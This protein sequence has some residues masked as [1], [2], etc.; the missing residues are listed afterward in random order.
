MTVEDIT[1]IKDVKYHEFIEPIAILTTITRVEAMERIYDLSFTLPQRMQAFD[2]LYKANSECLYDILSKLITTFAFT[3][4]NMMNKYILAICQHPDIPNMIRLETVSQL[5]LAPK[6]FQVAMD[7]L[8]ILCE[9]R[10]VDVPL[11]IYVDKLFLLIRYDAEK[12]SILFEKNILGDDAIPFQMRYKFLVQTK[13]MIDIKYFKTA[14]IKFLEIPS[15]EN[16]KF[17]IMSCSNLLTVDKIELDDMEKSRIIDFLTEIMLDEKIDTNIR[18]DSADIL[19]RYSPNP[20]LALDTLAK[21][22]TL[23]LGFLSNM[24]DNKQNVHTKGL[25]S[26]VNCVMDYIEARAPNTSLI[27][28]EIISRLRNIVIEMNTGLFNFSIF[29]IEF[30]VGK[31]LFGHSLMEIFMRLYGFIEVHQYRESLEQRLVEELIDM[32]DT[33][34]SGY[35]ARLLNTISGYADI[36]LQIS[37]EEQIQ[38]NLIGRLNACIRADENIDEILEELT[39]ESSLQRPELLKIFRAHIPKILEEMRVEFLEYMDEAD[40]DLYMRKALLAFDGIVMD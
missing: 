28:E 33:C 10:L 6:N 27:F 16:Y 20:Q 7:T 21:L 12:Y 29:R 19:I 3:N 18:A 22:G 40:F 4:V 39:I 32:S 23:G 38:A 8:G 34:T 24:Y 9:E 30:Q 35:Y 15:P 14:S 2:I 17:Q 11:V 37:W 1:L 36:Q 5:C 26:N 31:V 25:T 13:T